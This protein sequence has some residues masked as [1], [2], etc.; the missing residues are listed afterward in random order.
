M[1]L[2]L[3]NVKRKYKF[4]IEDVLEGNDVV[5]ANKCSQW[6]RKKEL[7]AEKDLIYIKIRVTFKD[8]GQQPI[9]FKQFYLEDTEGYFCDAVA[10]DDYLEDTLQSQQTVIGGLLFSVYQDIESCRLWFN[11]N[12]YYENSN[13]FILLDIALPSEVSET[14][15]EILSKQAM[16]VKQYT[17]QIEYNLEK[18]KITPENQTKTIIKKLARK[19]GIPYKRIDNGYLLRVPLPEGR[20]QN[21]IVTFSGK[22]EK[23]NDLITIATI[24]APVE[25]EKNNRIFLKLNPKLTFGGIGITTINDEEFYVITQTYSIQALQLK[26]LIIDAI[27]YIARQ[28]D[29]LEEKLIGKDIR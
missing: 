24:C 13:D 25:G 9:T 29:W 17:R 2:T 27:E 11:T 19:F 14:R 10:P 22:D 8:I 21:I 18:E 28:G 3:D 12:L 4:V 6:M 1:S 20:K 5:K 7:K 15:T 16:L 26:S 23:G